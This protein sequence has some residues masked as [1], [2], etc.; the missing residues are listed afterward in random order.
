MVTVVIRLKLSRFDEIVSANWFQDHGFCDS[1]F[2][3]FY[4]LSRDT[5][6]KFFRL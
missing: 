5:H 4:E 3:A 2:A 1:V 6:S